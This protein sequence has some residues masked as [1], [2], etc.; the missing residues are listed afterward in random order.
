MEV[1][2]QSIEILNDLIEINIDRVAGFSH[3]AKELD[4]NDIDLKAIFYRLRDESRENIHQLGSAIHKG[5]GEIEMGMSGSGALHR[6][7]LEIKATFS[8]HGRKSVLTEC[9][10]GEDAIKKAYEEALE[11]GNGLSAE[12]REIV[13]RQQ[14]GIIVAHDKIRALRNGWEIVK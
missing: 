12:F 2:E 1:P 9:E 11:P 6:M 5:N 10:R 4:E 8:G 3:A 13:F 7:W 14:Q